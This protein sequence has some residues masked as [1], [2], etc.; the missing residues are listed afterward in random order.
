MPLSLLPHHSPK[1]VVDQ[2]GDAGDGF[3]LPRNL[4][5]G[6]VV[7]TASGA[8]GAKTLELADNFVF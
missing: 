8:V 5:N 1:L 3:D 6:A 7:L 2:E 4:L